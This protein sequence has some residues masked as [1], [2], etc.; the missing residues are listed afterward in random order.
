MTWVSDG[1]ENLKHRHPRRRPTAYRGRQSFAQDDG[2]RLWRRL[3]HSCKLASM[4]RLSRFAMRSL[5]ASRGRALQPT[6]TTCSRSS[7]PLRW[8]ARHARARTTLGPSLASAAGGGGPG[9]PPPPDAIAGTG[10]RQASNVAEAPT[11]DYDSGSIQ[12]LEGLDPV[13]KRP[14]MY[15]GSTGR[16]GL[17]HLLYEVL[18]NSIDEV[19]AGNASVITVELCQETGRVD[20]TDDGRGIPVDTHPKVSRN[21]PRRAR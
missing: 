8:H 15:I 5:G 2:Q 7:A 12:V 10:T 18:D 1:G 19:Q 20:V 13:R 16:K 17:H 9:P 3:E 11:A 14:G 21:R 6:T 4:D